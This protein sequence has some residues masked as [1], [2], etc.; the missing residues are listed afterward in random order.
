MGTP[1]AVLLLEDSEDDC[2]LNVRELKGAG[3]TP[4]WRRVE[5]GEEMSAAL[6]ER[7]WDIV[8]ADHNLPRYDAISGLRLLKERGLDVPCILVSGSIGEEQLLEALQQGALDYVLKRDLRRL[9]SAVRRALD[10][11][12][13]RRERR[14]AELA[15]KESEE[16]Y[17][18]A[19]LGSRDG[20]WDWNL[21]TGGLYCSD[22]IKAIFGQEQ[23]GD[24]FNAFTSMIHAEDTGR[25]ERAMDAHLEHRTPYEVEYRIRTGQGE[26]RWVS[27]RGQA[28]WGKDGKPTRMAGSISDITARKNAEETLRQ[29]LEIIERQAEAI[30]TLSTPI[31][32]VWDGVLMMPVYGVIEGE[33]AA[34]MME[35]LLT[36]VARTRCRNAIIDLT[37]VE[38]VDAHT[39]DHILRLVSAVELIGAQ[40]IVVGIRPEVAQIMVAIGKG[41]D[42][43]ITLATLRDALVMCMR[44]GRRPR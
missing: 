33:R 26:V 27:V 8:L 9:A 39:A 42:K 20:I 44:T 21:A 22:R 4:A 15:L 19:V 23:L 32:E 29:K 34:Q 7:T 31:I 43:I 25:V 12:R 6:A 40:G 38:A 5:T 16:R 28:L 37:S 11:A 1:L 18:L 17:A 30:R 24:T 41:L 13:E 36:A 3:Y 35:V 14:R 10:V 2:L